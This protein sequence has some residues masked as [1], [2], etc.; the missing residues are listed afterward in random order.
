MKFA[1]MVRL[2]EDVVQGESVL[3]LIGKQRMKIENYRSILL[4]TDKRIRIQAKHYK[5]NI[6]GARLCIRYYDN[7]EM[8]ISGRIDS[9]EFEIN[10]R[11]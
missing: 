4:Y 11:L 3:T 9:V 1:H 2:P 8:E 5:L 10:R 6:N 7:E